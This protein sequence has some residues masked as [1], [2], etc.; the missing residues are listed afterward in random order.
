MALKNVIT[1]EAGSEELPPDGMRP[2]LLVGCLLRSPSHDF[3][4]ICATPFALC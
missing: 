3:I 4:N 2:A 1:L